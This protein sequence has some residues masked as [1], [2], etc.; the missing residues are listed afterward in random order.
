MIRSLIPSSPGMAEEEVHLVE[1]EE[2][3]DYCSLRLRKTTPPFTSLGW[4]LLRRN[5]RIL[6]QVL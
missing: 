6:S 3:G 4:I 1:E 5:M 2:G